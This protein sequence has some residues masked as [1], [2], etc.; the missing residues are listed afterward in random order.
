M[1]SNY[2][3]GVTDW[4]V[5]LGSR[6]HRYARTAVHRPTFPR[7]RI[8]LR[9][10]R[11]RATWSGVRMIELSVSPVACC[12]LSRKTWA[13]RQGFHPGNATLFTERE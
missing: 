10:C 5:L 3:S 1:H 4:R 12:S 9:E 11:I 13:C 8:F 2:L 7:P 6:P